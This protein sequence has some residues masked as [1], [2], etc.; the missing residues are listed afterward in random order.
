MSVNIDKSGEAEVLELNI[1]L[2]EDSEPGHPG[3]G[4]KKLSVH[5]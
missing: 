2:P 4:G 1:V 3:G 5:A